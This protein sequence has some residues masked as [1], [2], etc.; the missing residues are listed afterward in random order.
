[1]PL[2]YWD[3]A[4]IAT[5]YLINCT[6][7]KIQNFDTP[8]NRLYHEKP[9]YHSLRIFGCLCWPNLRPYN[10]KNWNFAQKNVPYWAIVIFTRVSNALIFPPVESISPEMSFLM[11][12][13]FRL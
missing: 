3:E 13:F 2:K 11:N 4:F 8:L 9:D 7:S 10:S 5:S 12:Q 6:P 1:M